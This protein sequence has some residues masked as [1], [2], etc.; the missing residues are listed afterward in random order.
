MWAAGFGRDERS[1]G[2]FLAWTAM[3]NRTKRTREKEAALL[4]AQRSGN[5]IGTACARVGIGRTTLHD[6]RAADPAFVA[7]VDEAIAYGT[8]VLE[9]VAR[10]RAV[11]VSDTLLIFLLKA[12]R[13]DKYRETTRHEHAGDAN[14][15]ITFV[16]REYV[17]P[18]V[19]APKP[20][21]ARE[22]TRSAHVVVR[23]AVQIR[24]SKHGPGVKS[25]A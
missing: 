14:N 2:G 9:D 20:P 17:P 3:A 12:R 22:P 13:T 4:D 5:A 10:D 19:S 15:P 8:D 24:S 25:Q 7:R 11:R 1:P 16:Y 18:P 23:G 6:W 21:S